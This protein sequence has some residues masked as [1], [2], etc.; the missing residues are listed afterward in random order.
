VTGDRTIRGGH[1]AP[2]PNCASL[3]RIVAA[4]VLSHAIVATVA[5]AELKATECAV[6]YNTN[7]AESEHIARYYAKMRQVP[8]DQLLGISLRPTESMSQRTYATTVRPAVRNFLNSHDWGERIRCLV[9]CYDVP[10]KIAKRRVSAEDRRRVAHLKT[11]LIDVINDATVLV[12][13]IE[14]ENEGTSVDPHADPSDDT[15]LREHAGASSKAATD[16]EVLLKLLNRYEK[17]QARFAARH[18]RLSGAELLRGRRDSFYFVNR[19]E[20]SGGILRRAPQPADTVPPNT[21]VRI[22]SI[23]RRHDR[24]GNQI[25][26]LTDYGVTA[27]QFDSAIPLLQQAR[28]LFGLA[29]ALQDRIRLLLGEDSEASFDSEL[30]LVMARRYSPAGWVRNT[31]RRTDRGGRLLDNDS[32]PTSRVLMVARLDAP[33]P[34]IVR[35]MIDDAITA[36]RKGLTGSMYIDARGLVNDEGLIEYDRDLIELARIVSTYTNIPVVLDRKPEVFAPGACKNVALYCGWY[37]LARYVDAFE[38]VPG[39][40][41][42]HIAS[43]ELVSLRSRYKRYWC[44]ELLKDGVAATFGATSEP[45]LQSFPLPTEFFTS[46]MT[47]E[48]T[49]VEAYSNTKFFNSWRLALLGDPLYNPF[50]HN[51]PL[52]SNWRERDK[53]QSPPSLPNE[54]FTTPQPGDR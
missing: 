28:G 26:R 8:T 10:L 31:L 18:E 42:V 32:T 15:Q 43:F 34:K 27:D 52:P 4:A 23:R 9:T 51:P 54:S 50:K 39:A 33:T 19:A 17:A 49:L 48:Q 30:S 16:R 25:E 3:V 6:I 12:E 2:S 1:A 21:A 44:K 20:G 53:K 7:S 13:R 41:A 36:E 29:V 5:F 47:G 24:L 35:R 40:I 45:Y 46:L 11:R 14:R 37:S 22:R 38:F